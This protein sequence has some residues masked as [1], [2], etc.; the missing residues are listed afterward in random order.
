M[1]GG[2]TRLRRDKR[3]RRRQATGRHGFHGDWREPLLLTIY[4]VDE[5][6]RKLN[7]RE[8]PI[9]NDGTFGHYEA[10]LNLLEMH[11]VKLGIA[12]CRS[13]LFIAD[14]ARWM[15]KH[16]PSLL[17]RLGV[18]PAKIS[19][20][21]DFYHAV[22]HLQ[23]FA[24]QAF[25]DLS[26]STQWVNKSRSL[27][28]RG[29]FNALLARMSALIQSAKPKQRPE[30][31]KALEYFSLQPERFGY[32]RIADMKLPIGSGSIESLVRQVVNL[33]LKGNGKFWLEAHAE[34]M[35]HGRCHWAAGTWQQF[36]HSVLRAC[37]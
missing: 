29:R 18:A 11:L 28:K 12:H 8:M 1:D 15:W 32:K 37:K 27:L 31:N 35:L 4:A 24:Q 20:L 26:D 30:M 10:L 2:R 9:T 25:D 5:Q 13:V 7:T 33:R 23:A 6:G 21:I 34:I 17:Q 3:G 16:I 36:S 14:G 22:E 19:Q